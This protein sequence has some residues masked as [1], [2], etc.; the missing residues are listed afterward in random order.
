MA[1]QLRCNLGGGD[2]LPKSDRAGGAGCPHA[3]GQEANLVTLI[4]IELIEKGTFMRR[5]TS[6]GQNEKDD[7]SRIKLMW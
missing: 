3:S 2:D 7:F 1:E 6:K 4:A 5:C